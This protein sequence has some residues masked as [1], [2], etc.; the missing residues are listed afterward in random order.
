MRAGVRACV[1]VCVCVRAHAM[2]ALDCAWSYVHVHVTCHAAF[3]RF[4]LFLSSDLSCTLVPSTKGKPSQALR[5]WDAKL[6]VWP[7][8]D[9]VC[10]IRFAKS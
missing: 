4:Q 6:S 8:L 9:A 5:L 1:C 3:K 7:W 10:F 2:H